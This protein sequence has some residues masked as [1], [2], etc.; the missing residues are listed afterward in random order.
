MVLMGRQAD[1]PSRY[2]S[3]LSLSPVHFFLNN[4]VSHNNNNKPPKTWVKYII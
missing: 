3:L 1:L 4:Q 2:T